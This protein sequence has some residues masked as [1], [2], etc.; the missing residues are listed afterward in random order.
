MIFLF[1]NSQKLSSSDASSVG[2]NRVDQQWMFYEKGFRSYRTTA[3]FGNISDWKKYKYKTKGYGY[4]PKK[5]F[6]KFT[7]N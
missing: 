4:I 5:K 7:Y 1:I 6:L 2:C 3:T